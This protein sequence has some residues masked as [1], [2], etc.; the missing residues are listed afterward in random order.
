MNLA[1]HVHVSLPVVV[2]RLLYGPVYHHRLDPL[3]A[4]D[5]A[6]A[7]PGGEF[8]LAVRVRGGDAGHPQLVF[9]GRANTQDPDILA[10]F[11]PELAIGLVGPQEFEFVHFQ[12]RGPVLADLQHMGMAVRRQPLDDQRLDPEAAKEKPGIAAAVGLLDA[13]CQRT[14]GANRNP[15]PTRDGGSCQQAEGNDQFVLL[16]QRFAV[17]RNFVQKNPGRQG[18]PAQQLIIRILNSHN[19]LPVHVDF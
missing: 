18:P 5:R 13:V 10:E 2:H 17:R 19:F 12:Q 6:Q 8:Q 15:T 1:D 9:S 4:H 14:L 3:A 16:P 11:F 7:A